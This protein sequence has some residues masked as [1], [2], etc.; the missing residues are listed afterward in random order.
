MKNIFK[1]KYKLHHL[2]NIS[3]YLIFFIAGFIMG[4]GS[5]EKIFDIIS[6]MLK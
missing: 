3:F 2:I 4:G 6:N 1:L 5:I